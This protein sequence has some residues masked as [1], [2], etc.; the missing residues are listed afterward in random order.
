[1][2]KTNIGKPISQVVKD[3]QNLKPRL[4]GIAGV[5][6][7]NH[8]KKGFRDQ[9]F[10]DEG[11]NAWKELAPETVKKKGSTILV[12]TGKTRRA[13]RILYQSENR[14]MV[15]IDE[16]EIPWAKAHNEGFKGTVNVPAYMRRNRR[17]DTHNIKNRR[18]S[19]NGIT[20]V[21]AHTMKMNLPKRQ[22]VG[23]SAV[24]NM[25]VD[26]KVNRELKNV[27]G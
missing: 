15:G 10:T 21:R 22:M 8:F 18:V 13:I 9:G 5:E 23:E 20:Y 14:V 25:K 19:S 4:P 6:A 7:V 1:M 3:W 16:A 17:G 12:K 24:L 27:L 11:F 2:T 26:A